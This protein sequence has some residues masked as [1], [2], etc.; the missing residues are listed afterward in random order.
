MFNHELVPYP[1][2]RWGNHL[3]ATEYAGGKH[4][5]YL[6]DNHVDNNEVITQQQTAIGGTIYNR[7]LATGKAGD[8]VFLESCGF[9]SGN[10]VTGLG[11][12][13]TLMLSANPD[14][15][16]AGKF[17]DFIGKNV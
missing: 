1:W 15:S 4:I 12:R 13:K 8:V 9:H 14:A 6:S 17:L 3:S 7:F 11:I 10:I 2:R 16:Y 5:G